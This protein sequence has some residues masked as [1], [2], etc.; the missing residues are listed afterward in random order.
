[1]VSTAGVDD[2]SLL[3]ADLPVVDVSALGRNR[4]DVR[5]CSAIG[6]SIVAIICEC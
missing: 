6:F 4:L 5:D 2:G 3:V 1:M